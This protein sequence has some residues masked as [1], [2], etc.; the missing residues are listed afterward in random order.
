MRLA[1]GNAEVVLS[2]VTRT[3]HFNADAAN[4]TG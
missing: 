3:S 1:K 4:K 2:P